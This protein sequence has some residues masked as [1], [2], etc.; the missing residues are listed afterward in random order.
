MTIKEGRTLLQ[1]KMIFNL[2][3]IVQKYDALG[4]DCIIKKIIFLFLFH[5]FN[6]LKIVFTHSEPSCHVQ[7]YTKKQT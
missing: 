3:H 7:G 2:Y 4:H 5:T 6:E 1:K